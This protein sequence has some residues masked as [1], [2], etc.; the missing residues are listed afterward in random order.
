MKTKITIKQIKNAGIFI[1]AHVLVVGL[2]LALAIT[3]A[4]SGGIG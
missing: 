2:L 3:M 4:T 1:S